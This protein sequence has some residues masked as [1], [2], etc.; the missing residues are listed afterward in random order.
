M[1]EYI[2]GALYLFNILQIHLP[3]FLNKQQP[4][5]E[6]VIF[7][8]RSKTIV[9]NL[10]ILP[11]GNTVPVVKRQT[12]RDKNYMQRNLASNVYGYQFSQHI[13]SDRAHTRTR[14]H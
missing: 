14:S 12:I 4:A 9:N 13:V 2:L 1:A 10:H 7:G 6:I 11:I 3:F 8:G 5:K